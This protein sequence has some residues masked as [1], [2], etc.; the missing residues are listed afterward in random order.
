ML[1]QTVDKPRSYSALGRVVLT[2]AL[3]LLMFVVDYEV[4][5]RGDALFVL[6]KCFEDSDSAPDSEF[7]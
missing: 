1:R 6:S 5:G 3:L 2:K 7:E 4:L